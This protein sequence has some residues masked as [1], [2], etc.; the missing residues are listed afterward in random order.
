[1]KLTVKQ[2][3][4]LTLTGLLLLFC[5]WF[6]MEGYVADEKKGMLAVA[7]TLNTEDKADILAAEN[8]ERLDKVFEI[9]APEIDYQG[10]VCETGEIINIK[11]MFL[12]KNGGSDTWQP[13]D[14]ESDFR[15]YILDITDSRG[16][17]CMEEAEESTAE[18]SEEINTLLTYREATGEVCFH[19]SGIY[20][21][22]VCVYGNGGRKTEKEVAIPVEV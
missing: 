7:G 21:I 6:S 16:N 1:M 22:R 5:L 20:R 3:T 9:S 4:E 2:I 10:G 19:K 13:G 17:T 18:E 14:Y 8:G 15:L 11:R 12:V